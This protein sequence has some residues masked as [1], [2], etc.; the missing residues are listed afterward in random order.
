LGFGRLQLRPKNGQFGVILKVFRG[1]QV[2]AFCKKTTGHTGGPFIFW[3]FWPFLRKMCRFRGWCNIT[4]ICCQKELPPTYFL[5]WGLGA[6]WV[7]VLGGVY[8]ILT[9][10]LGDLGLRNYSF[11]ILFSLLGFDALLY[12]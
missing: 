10:C 11:D 12:W 6:C 9:L 2:G 4:P 1:C 3:R 8:C 7:S 5:S